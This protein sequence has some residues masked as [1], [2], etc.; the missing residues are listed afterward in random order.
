MNKLLNLIFD[1][2]GVQ[3]AEYAIILGVL[4]TVGATVIA[5]LATRVSGVFSKASTAIPS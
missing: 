2:E 1:E 3:V 5:V 4:V